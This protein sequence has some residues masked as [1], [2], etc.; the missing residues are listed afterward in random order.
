VLESAIAL[1]REHGARDIDA[2]IGPCIHQAS[3]EVGPEFEARFI[4]EDTSYARL[5]TPSEGDR[6]RFDLPA[7]CAVRLRAAGVERIEVAPL[8]TYV[9]EQRLFSH[10]RS[11]HRKEDG[12]GRNC[13]VI[14][15]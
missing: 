12:Y 4:A 14:V 9:E 6:R 15:L 3:Y 11:V 1:M 7:F 8:D 13:A 5:F 2:A 10:R